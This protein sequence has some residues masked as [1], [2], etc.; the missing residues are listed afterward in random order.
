MPRNEVGVTPPF[1]V[2]ILGEHSC[3]S[4]LHAEDRPDTRR[5][6]LEPG[7]HLAVEV[8]FQRQ[9]KVKILSVQQ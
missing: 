4:S 9:K 2:R 6:S 5:Y 3:L 1:V 8:E 7:A